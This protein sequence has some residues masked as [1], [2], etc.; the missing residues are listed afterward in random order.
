MQKDLRSCLQ[1][2]E[3][4][5]LLLRVKKEVNPRFEI[6]ALMK[7]AEKQGKAIL[8][9]SVKRPGFRVTNNICGSRKAFALF[10]ET[11][12]EKI[13]QEWIRRVN[14]PIKPEVCSSGPV[15]ETIKKGSE[16][17]LSELPIVTHCAK[18]AGPYITAGI[19]V[20]KDPETGTRNV[21]INRMQYKGKNKLGIRMMP[22]QHLGLIREKW[23][24]KG[25]PLEIAVAIGSHPFD[26]LAAATTVAY[27]TDEFTISSSL[28]KEPLQL[29]KC[30]AVDLEVP[31]FAEI[32]LEGEVLPEVWE[33]EGPFG[34]FMQYYV[35]VMDNN[36]FIVKALTHRKDPIYQTI[37][38]GSLEDTHYLALSREARLYQAV[39]QVAD[40]QALSLVP[41]ILGCA[42]SIRKRFEGEPKNVAAA[43]FG[44][45]SW[46]KYCV[47]VD[48]DVNVFDINDVW[49]AM[50]T[51]SRPDRGLLIMENA[52][53][54]PRDPFHIHTSKLGI[55]AT[56]P[57]NQWEEFERKTVPGAD[58]IHL[59][60][61][62]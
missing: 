24:K 3:T 4:S 18:D 34:D 61:Y 16:V 54:F 15:K 10:F 31:A 30:E 7:K 57:L 38:A 23:E 45:Y 13:V 12:P 21:S 33:P 22:P 26:I 44:A 41:T 32:V 39:S 14:H 36:V 50:A 8:F 25:K 56:A 46:L 52:L 1:L 35:P 5:D 20:A 55:D 2:L 49:W 62:L 6:P 51:R 17:D 53:G 37:Q 48:H 60:D 42:I 43:A 29:V 19:V 27:G 58:D 11:S 59:E 9:E 47:V 40:I 28:R